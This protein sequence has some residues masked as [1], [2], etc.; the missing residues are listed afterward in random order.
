MEGADAE[1]FGG[2]AFAPVAQLVGEDG[3]DF[4]DG[5]LFDQGVVDDDLLLPG[6]TR[7]VGV[8]V[9]ASL[10]AVDDVEF[11]ERELEALG[12]GFH[13]LLEG[14]GLE[15][16][17][18]IE[19]RYDEDGIDS[20][21]GE[22]DDKSK[23]PEPEEELI[24]G[25]L[26][27]FEEGRAERDAEGEAER[28]AFEQVRDVEGEGLFVEAEFL[29]EDEVIVVAEGDTKECLNKAVR[30]G[31]EERVR[32]FAAKAVRDE[33]AGQPGARH[34][35]EA[36]VYVVHDDEV[37]LDLAEESRNEVELCFCATVGLGFIVGLLVDLMLELFRDGFA[38][39]DL[40]LAVGKVGLEC[41]LAN[42]EGEDERLPSG[43][44]V[45]RLS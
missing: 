1:E 41:E 34:G 30:E 40:V 27:D 22:L 31:E 16:G 2:V 8:A 13:L 21:R 38:L 32:D 12:Q 26:D 24:A 19:E 17:E 35:P 36:R 43:R 39:E 45:S 9:R 3:F 20:Y 33:G 44:L 7:E 29:L 28:L 37:V 23:S 18:F 6:Q 15:G 11:C 42:G 14:P 10:A 25:L 4:G 5:G